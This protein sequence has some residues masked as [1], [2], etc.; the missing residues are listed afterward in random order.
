MIFDLSPSETAG[1]RARFGRFGHTPRKGQPENSPRQRSTATVALRP[2]PRGGPLDFSGTS[3]GITPTAVF[4]L[5][6]G[7]A[8]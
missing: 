2:R 6:W 1:S 5:A 4:R 3:K 8:R 7:E